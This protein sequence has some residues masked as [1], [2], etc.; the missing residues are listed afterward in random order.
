MVQFF[1]KKVASLAVVFSLSFLLFNSSALAT[2]YSFK[3]PGTP[4]EEGVFIGSV[5]Y[6]SNAVREYLNNTDMLRGLLLEELGEGSK[7][8][9]EYI[10]PH[11]GVKHSQDTICAR[12]IYDLDNGLP[13]NEILGDVEGPY[14]N[15]DSPL[16][17][18]SIDFR[19]C[20]GGDEVN[21]SISDRDVEVAY[22]ELS[23][24]FNELNLKETTYTRSKPGLYRQ[25]FK[26]KFELKKL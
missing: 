5:T 10:S 18:A 26:L 24:V 9:F 12:N 16:D 20:V 11:S 19:S 25:R 21:S 7:F 1:F 23:S 14:F 8:S 22:S 3:S 15:F 4:G 13:G 2:T 6:D 17:L